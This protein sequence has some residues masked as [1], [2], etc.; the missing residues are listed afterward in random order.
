MHT[1]CPTVSVNELPSSLH[2]PE[3]VRQRS[4]SSSDSFV[5]ISEATSTNDTHIDR[6]ASQDPDTWI[7]LSS[8]NSHNGQHSPHDKEETAQL[9]AKVDQI[10]LSDDLDEELLHVEASD[11]GTIERKGEEATEKG[12]EGGGGQGGEDSGSDWENWDD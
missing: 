5:C 12:K 8:E 7:Y 6:A 11:G 10:A 9:A 1:H 4:E 2:K 3:D